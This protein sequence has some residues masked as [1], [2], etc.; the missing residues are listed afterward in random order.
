MD[1]TRKRDRMELLLTQFLAVLDAK[2]IGAF[3]AFQGSVGA[4]PEPFRIHHHTQLP[5]DPD[6][7]RHGEQR[8]GVK[9]HHEHHGGKHHQVIPVKD[10]AGGAAFVAHHQSE[11]T[12]DQY[13]DQIAHIEEGAGEKQM[14]IL[15]HTCK[16]QHTQSCD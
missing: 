12:P 13:A 15:Q 10:P 3:G 5:N 11:G 1:V 6:D 8:Q 7:H 14:L 2:L 4:L 9:T 16:F